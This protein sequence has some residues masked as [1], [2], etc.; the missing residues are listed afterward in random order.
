WPAPPRGGALPQACAAPLR[1]RL[2]PRPRVCALLPTAVARPVAWPALPARGPGAPAW[3]ASRLPPGFAPPLGAG[4][5][6]PAVFVRLVVWRVLPAGGPAVRR[7]VEHSPPLLDGLAPRRLAGLFLPQ[8]VCAPP[9]IVF[10]RLPAW[11][12][13]PARGPAVAPLVT[14]VS[15]PPACARFL[16]TLTLCLQLSALGSQ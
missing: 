6:L 9:L 12:V 15:L 2:V 13:L 3:R 4:A 8:G 14:L 5:P 11:P 7:P 10:A 1:G 16:K